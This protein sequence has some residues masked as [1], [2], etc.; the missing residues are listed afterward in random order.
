MRNIYMFPCR[1]NKPEVDFCN[2][3]LG[4]LVHIR[5]SRNVE[6]VQVQLEISLSWWTV[7][8]LYTVCM[9]CRD[10]EKQPK[11][12]AGPAYLLC[13]TFHNSVKQ[14][15]GTVSL[16]C[17]LC[18]YFVSCRLLHELQDIGDRLVMGPNVWKSKRV[19][20]ELLCYRVTKFINDPNSS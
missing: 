17:L 11:L 15:A 20:K 14:S 4:V 5:Y 6:D 3:L 16:F 10:W 8:V 9:T 2:Y 13:C 18:A 19:S 1:L 12:A 7:C